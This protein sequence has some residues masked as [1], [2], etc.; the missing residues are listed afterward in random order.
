MKNKRF[1]SGSLS[2]LICAITL[3]VAALLN[4][5]VS[6]LPENVKRLDL[7]ASGMYKISEQTLAELVGRQDIEIVYL[8]ESGE[9]DLI[10]DQMLTRVDEQCAGI[11]LRRIDPVLHPADAAQYTD[12]AP[13]SFVVKSALRERTVSAYDLY[14]YEIE[15]YE[16]RRYSYAEY[17][18][19]KSYYP[20][21]SVTEYYVGERKLLSAL[22][23]VT[24]KR[25]PTVYFTTGHGESD[26]DTTFTAYLDADNVTMS[27]LDS[28]SFTSLPDDAD[29]IVLLNP[30]ED[31]SATECLMLKT[32]INSGGHVVLY[33]EYDTE[34]LENLEKL[35]AELGMERTDGVVRE[36]DSGMYTGTSLLMMPNLVESEFTAG[37]SGTTVFV[38]LSHG[39]L[40][41]ETVPDGV[42]VT[43]ILTTSDDA[44]AR[45]ADSEYVS[46]VMTEGD[47]AGPFMLGADATLG[48]GSLT[49]YGSPYLAYEAFDYGGTRYT[50]SDTLFLNTVEKNCDMDLSVSAI[51]TIPGKQTVSD[52]LVVPESEKNMWTAVLAVI[53]PLGVLCY[54]GYRVRRRNRA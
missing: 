3:A 13:G 39:I 51:A 38:P 5:C 4:I 9:E 19:Y 10:C 18:E 6:L 20:D 34:P 35:L 44:F 11:T 36:G 7:S 31:L 32:F 43:P 45:P 42:T 41:T 8:V 27:L 54:G 33:T 26:P 28:A 25:L 37:L 21:A 12:L 15:G 14:E 24:A 1:L 49:W 29:T 48:E 40:Q 17:Y 47:V 2:L 53:L 30:K 46:D 22:S 50:V 23:Y 52:L 16:E